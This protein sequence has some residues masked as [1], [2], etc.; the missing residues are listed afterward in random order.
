M[1]V[2]WLANFS[3]YRVMTKLQESYEVVKSA[4]KIRIPYDVFATILQH[5]N[6]LLYDKHT[7]KL[8]RFY[9]NFTVVLRCFVNYAPISKSISC[10]FGSQNPCIF[11][12]FFIYR[13]LKSESGL[14]NNTAVLKSV[15]VVG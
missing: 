10:A 13:V 1:A 2:D 9:D 12:G 4:F 15:V 6:L 8:R 14:C 7:T 5:C 11:K 3:D